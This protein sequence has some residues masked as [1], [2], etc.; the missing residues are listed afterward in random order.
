MALTYIARRVAPDH[1]VAA[2]LQAESTA[3]DAAWI[4]DGWLRDRSAAASA[5]LR[6]ATA[7]ANDAGQPQ[8]DS[9]TL[10]AEARGLQ[11][12]QPP[13]GELEPGRSA[14]VIAAQGGRGLKPTR[15]EKNILAQRLWRLKQKARLCSET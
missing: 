5:G 3:E 8:Q 9:G 1:V 13:A 10:G 14:A 4:P 12:Q 2:L 7:I 6:G 11:E 15:R